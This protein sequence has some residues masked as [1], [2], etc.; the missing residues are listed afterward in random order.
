MRSGQHTEVIPMSAYIDFAAIKQR[1]KIEDVA[2]WLNLDCKVSNN[3][4]RTA[5]PACRTGGPRALAITPHKASYYCFAEGSGG[6]LIKLASHILGVGQRDSAQQI[7]EHFG[8]L[9]RE[10]AP[11]PRQTRQEPRSEAFGPLDY[12][13]ADHPAV[14]AVGL[15]KA[16][17]EALGIGYASRGLM[18]GTV[19]VPVRLE[20]GTLAGYI[21]I[22]D[23]RLP[24][25]W[26][27]QPK[28]VPLKRPA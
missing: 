23:A 4:L 27:L 6:D 18:R 14:E 21:G 22:T 17:A 26:H 25:Q 8:L 19:A 24:K 16:T 9:D 13:E 7:A 10:E 1:V 2:A 3:Q 15:D 11:A 20:D 12:L 5:C 28:V